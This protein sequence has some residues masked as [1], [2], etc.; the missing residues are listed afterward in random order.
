MSKVTVGK[1]ELEFRDAEGEELDLLRDC[2]VLD[3]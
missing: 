2:D 1:G 3:G